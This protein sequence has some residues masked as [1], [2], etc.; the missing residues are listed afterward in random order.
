[1]Y[2]GF[3]WVVAG[4]SCKYSNEPACTIGAGGAIS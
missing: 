4:Y 3:I 1:M 2:T